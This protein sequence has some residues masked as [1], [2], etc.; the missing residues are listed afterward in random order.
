[1]TC[2]FYSCKYVRE[3]LSLLNKK[4]SN[5]QQ[6]VKVDMLSKQYGLYFQIVRQ[7]KEI[8]IFRNPI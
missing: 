2:I 3:I 1:M 8:N 7:F 5:F 4:Q 6:I